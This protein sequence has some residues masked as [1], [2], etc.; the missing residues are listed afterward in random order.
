[1]IYTSYFDNLEKLPE[2]V[3]PVAICG[4]S[5]E[6]YDGLQYKKLAPK[7]D[8]FMK[9]KENQ[10]NDYY[11][12][13]YNEQVL[14]KLE[15]MRVVKEIEQLCGISSDDDIYICLLCYEKPEGFCHR[16]LVAAWLTKNGCECQEFIEPRSLYVVPTQ[17]DIDDLLIH[18]CEL[19][20]EE[21]ETKSAKQG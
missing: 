3:I 12:S 20:T 17:F 9:W 14:D 18:L 16:H 10:D 4:Q 15:L 5:P 7:Y 19:E 11:I 21:D 6:W 13:C 1:M 8:F 2:N